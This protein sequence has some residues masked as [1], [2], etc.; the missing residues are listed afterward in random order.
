[1]GGET[2]VRTNFREETGLVPFFFTVYYFHIGIAENTPQSFENFKVVMSC[3]N[4]H[5]L[6]TSSA[7]DKI[8]EQ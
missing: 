6:I 8:L 7:P 2:V 5:C 3:H 4:S 1:M